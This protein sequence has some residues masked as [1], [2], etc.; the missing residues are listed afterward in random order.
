[1]C[2]CVY[3]CVCARAGGVLAVREHRQGCSASHEYNIQPC[4]S[5]FIICT[6]TCHFLCPGAA[7]KSFLMNKPGFCNLECMSSWAISARQDNL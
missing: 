3:V 7:E 6:C 5:P 2:V 1:M 4:M